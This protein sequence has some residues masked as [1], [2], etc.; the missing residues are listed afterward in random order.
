MNA[1]ARRLEGE[2]HA[3]A[4][5]ERSQLA[6]VRMIPSADE[7]TQLAVGLELFQQGRLL[8]ERKLDHARFFLG[9]LAVVIAHQLFTR[10]AHGACLRIEGATSSA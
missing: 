6:R 1:R 3:V 5:I 8:L 4:D 9:Q 10:D 2:Q 7:A